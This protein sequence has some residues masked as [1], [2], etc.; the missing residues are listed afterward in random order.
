MTQRLFRPW[1]LLAVLIALLAVPRAP[2]LAA[3]AGSEALFQ[4]DNLVA[5]CIVPFDNRKR[6]PEERAEMMARLGIKRFAYDWRAEHIPTFDE[7]MEALKRYGIELTAFWFPGALNDE[8]RIILDLLKRH[9][10]K[11]QLWITMGGGDIECTPEEQEARVRQHADVIRPI[12]E[13]AAEIGC[14]VG[15]YNH[16]AWFG[17]PDNQIAIIQ[18]LN[19]PNVGIVYNL[20]HGHDQVDDLAG[21]LERMMP[22][23][24]CFN[25]NG[26]N[27]EGDKKGQKILPIA[28]GELDLQLLKILKDSGYAGPVGILGHTDD[29]AEDTL[30]DNLEGLDWLLP[31]LDGGAPPG[32]KPVPQR[33][34]LRSAAQGAPSL[35]A[36]HG[37]ALSGGLV[38]E[39]KP[40][41]AA[42]PLTVGLNARIDGAASFN[43]L[44]AHHTKASGAHWEIFTEAGS[45]HLSAYLPGMDP[46]HLRTGVSIADG[47]WRRVTFQYAPDAVRLYLD[48]ALAGETAIR[49]RGLPA[50]PGGL[51]FGR[52]VE[53]GFGCDGLVD[54]VHIARG[55]QPPDPMNAG[56]PAPGEHTIGVWNFDDRSAETE[57]R[58]P[59]VENPDFRAAL[60]E[61]Q[62]IPAAP[63]DRLTPANGSPAPDAYQTWTRSHGDATNSRYTASAQINRDTVKNL[64]V[65]WTYRSGDGEG[66]I[67]CN[68]IVVGATLYVPTPGNAL[69]A[70]DARTGA[71]LWRF[72]GEGRPAHRGLVYWPGEGE[73]APRLLV[74]IGSDL[75]ALDP[76]TGAP[77]TAFG[78][79]GKVAAGVSVVAGAVYGRV[80]VLPGFERDVWG[81]DAVT[82]ERRWTF[83]TIPAGDQFG[84]DTW[85]NIETGAN[86]WGGMALDEQR[87]IAYIAT[88]SPKPN[89]VGVH[90]TGRNL[91]A[92]SVI[93]LDALTGE[94]KWHFQEIRHD[95]WDLDIP[96]PPNLVTVTKDGKRVDAVAQ[97]TKI[98]N[99]LLLDRVTGEPLY[100][101]RLRRAPG[102]ALPGERTWSY[103]PDIDLP[104]PFAR[105]NFS[106]EDITRRSDEA[107]TYVSNIVN[108]GNHGFFEPFTEGKPTIFY[109]LHGG[110]EW[111]GAAYDPA[112]SRLYVTANEMAW[113]ITVI[114]ATEIRRAPGQPPSR[115]QR[116]Y[117]ERCMQCHGAGFEGNSI[118]PPL[119]GL[120]GRL[121]D[122]AVRALLKTGRNAMPAAEGLTP[123]DEQALLDYVFLREPG[124]EVVQPSDGGVPRYTFN[125]YNKLLDHEGYPGVKPPWGTLNCIDLNT[126]R[127]AWKV[128]LG[129][130]P[131][132]AIWGEDDTGAEN[133]GGAMVTA[134][135]LVFCAGTPDNLIRAF[136]AESGAE[137][138]R[139]E[140]P[141]GGYAPPASY[142]VDGRQYVVIAA[143]GGGKLG[144]ETG[145][146]WVAFAL[147]E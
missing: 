146:A 74:S 80:L 139:H 37:M 95:I 144:T 56:P 102:S 3:Q 111:T 109:G 128:P 26:M 33:A 24:Y 40:E 41:Y 5:W 93:A 50:V 90:H 72:R 47:Q 42:P 78:D 91:F 69:A 122:A 8:A 13:A 7:E 138:W 140:L 39:G 131:E 76:A 45:G 61:F 133:F 97:V 106:P 103:Q 36:A 77:I 58:T 81:I 38:V 10:I 35:S 43:I 82:G 6:G 51:A 18:V 83:H 23:L 30:R 137:L 70:L 119:I 59:D 46:D 4:R 132:L 67:Q 27:P 116:L 101:V 121:D 87:G 49:A 88:G 85:E 62:V 105:L 54:D 9:E 60:P 53:G 100:P 127:L 130:Y 52:L 124:L 57:A 34:S 44:A 12:A 112:S 134:G 141:F 108:Q 71:E 21:L 14:T 86:C 20:H 64:Q 125:G 126:G 66:H 113:S 32:P 107:H 129:H 2:T 143:T 135:G 65:A 115:G 17:E 28:Q 63:A 68:P 96:A 79:G 75:W 94:R 25:L 117:E 147:P 31:Q 110:A 104:E 120:P 114:R 48:G 84:A 55:I 73:H 19:L 145:D 29:D 123:E 98:G 16:G 92:N 15:L 89:F 11:T 22:Y 1:V 99:T 118:S 142:E 136:D